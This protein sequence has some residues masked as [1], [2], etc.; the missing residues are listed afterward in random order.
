MTTEIEYSTL[1]ADGV[2]TTYLDIGSPKAPPIV[3]LHDGAFGSDARSCWSEL[4]PTLIGRYR[5]IAPDLLGYGGSSKIYDF[6]LDAR[7][8]RLNS[9]I[10]LC[11]RL[12]LD[13][14]PFV[15]SSFGGS[16]T[17]VGAASGRLPL[18]VGISIS[19]TAGPYMNQEVFHRMHD[20]VPSAESAADLSHLLALSP[21]Q[22]EIDRRL[23]A[24]SNPSHRKALGAARIALAGDSS[25]PQRTTARPIAS[26]LADIQS[27]FLFIAGAEDTLLDLGWE[28]KMA[29]LLPNAS[30][31]LIEHASHLV[32]VDQPELVA[33]EIFN[34]ID[35]QA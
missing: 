11:H 9:V 4:I 17:L 7:S 31:T 3:L 35:L 29:Q 12:D 24:S 32:Q 23:A 18:T 1:V 34:F 22:A 10:A 6:D 30:S 14:A 15:G 19:G 21:D 20:Y 25:V 13:R 27:S 8:L 33:S 16:I 28:Q 2:T 5:V 26:Q